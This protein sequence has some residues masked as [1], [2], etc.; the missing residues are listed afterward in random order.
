MGWW[1]RMRNKLKSNNK[2]AR[3][4][5]YA[6]SS[7]HY[8]SNPPYG[9]Q[10]FPDFAGAPAPPPSTAPYG[11]GTSS[12][13]IAAGGGGGSGA[14]LAPTTTRDPFA[15]PHTPPRHHYHLR[16]PAFCKSNGG[17]RARV[18]GGMKK[19]TNKSSYGRLSTEKALV[20]Q[21]ESRLSSSSAAFRPSMV[22]DRS[23][24]MQEMSFEL[25][26]R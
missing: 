4:V 6:G 21:H 10:D 7:S 2:S 18:G 14:G 5:R 19:A 23:A 12:R 8:Q 1:R 16:V 15:D 9:A 26:R 24:F 3:P 17:G 13:V 20:E 25:P 22:S 11:R